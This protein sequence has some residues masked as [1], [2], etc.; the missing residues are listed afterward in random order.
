[1]E[2]TTNTWGYTFNSFCQPQSNQ[3]E[4][5]SSNTPNSEN[6]TGDPRLMTCILCQEHLFIFSHTANYGDQRAQANFT[7]P[8]YYLPVE[9]ANLEVIRGLN[10]KKR[11]FALQIKDKRH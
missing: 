10:G 2:V 1:M 4:G 7:L 9:F 8:N 11:G 5:P 6:W 3:E